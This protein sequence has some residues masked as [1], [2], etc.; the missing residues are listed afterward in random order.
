MKLLGSLYSML[1]GL[2]L[3]VCLTLTYGAAFPQPFGFLA[4]AS[5]QLALLFFADSMVCYLIH[6]SQGGE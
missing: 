2:V 5:P 6:W 3:G 1:A 4:Y